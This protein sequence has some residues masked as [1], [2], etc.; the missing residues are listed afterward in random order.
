MD[1]KSQSTTEKG[2]TLV[3]LG[4]GPF[5]ALTLEAWQWLESLETLYL[6]TSHHPTV[7]HFPEA[8]KWVSFDGLSVE[9][10]V[11]QVLRLGQLPGG[12]T[13]A[14]PGHPFLGEATCP[15]IAQSA[16]EAGIPVR[17]IAGVSYLEPTLQA[18]GLEGTLPD[19]ALRDALS[20]AQRQTPGFSSSAAA[21]VTQISSPELACAVQQ[22]LMTVYPGDHS[23]QWVSGVG[24]AEA[25]VAAFSLAG[26][27][28]QR[29]PDTGVSLFIPPL[30]KNASFESFFLCA[31]RGYIIL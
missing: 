7:P 27:G 22:V 15:A 17:V 5:E 26:L 16:A 11:E 13:Y 4:P 28:R 1:R 8:L 31:Y 29:F 18:L 12:M 2:I 9:A 3:G 19:L 14:V 20:L 24:T 30:G 25:K 21:L 10:I 23:V 6:R